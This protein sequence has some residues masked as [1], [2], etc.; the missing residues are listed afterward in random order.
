MVEGKYKENNILNPQIVN[1]YGELLL[2]TMDCLPPDLRETAE[3][4][5]M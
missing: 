1:E 4:C 3:V 5:F 2:Q